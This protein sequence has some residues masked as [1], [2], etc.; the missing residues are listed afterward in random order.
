MVV[1]CRVCHGS[2]S[3]LD[4]VCPLCD[5][6]AF[7]GEDE[8]DYFVFILAGQSNMVGRGK[9]AELDQALVDF[10]RNHADVS[11]AYDIDKSAK[12][13]KNSTSGNEF[14]QLGRE[15][16]WSDGGQCYSYG[17]EWG[18]AHTVIERLLQAQSN[19]NAKQ[20][21]RIYFIKFAMGSTN[22]HE[23]WSPEGKYFGEFV[24]FTRLML[25][26]VADLET[27]ITQRLCREACPQSSVIID[28]MFWNQ[29]D[30]D[31]SGRFEMRDKYQKNLVNFV[32]LVW[33]DLAGSQCSFPFVPLELH[34]KVDEN[35][36]STKKYR[37]S[38]DKVN[39]A[40][41]DG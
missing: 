12:E 30:S 2:G 21:P 29:G 5:G 24:K 11:M 40:I 34:E 35:S 23:D 28:A 37:K 13:Q 16:Q 36:K 26:K 14:I 27:G 4:E 22:L 32:H 25:Q 7:F 18:V 6:D 1:M 39:D 38:M 31:A 8:R 20:L 3:L 15:T 19:R 10:V 41:C 17:P 33:K 9:A